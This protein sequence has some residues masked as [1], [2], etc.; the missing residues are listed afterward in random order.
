[1]N[2]YMPTDRSNAT[3]SG[4]SARS[5]AVRGGGSAPVV[6]GL[7][8]HSDVDR[9]GA[10]SFGF[11]SPATSSPPASTTGAFLYNLSCA[12]IDCM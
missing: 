8:M 7:W 3:E 6:H 10:V 5:G 1:M 9:H 11:N 12:Q 4:D 2:D